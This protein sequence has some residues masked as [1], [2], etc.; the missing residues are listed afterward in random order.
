MCCYHWHLW[1][2]FGWLPFA[3][4]N[5]CLI[6]DRMCL[7]NPIVTPL[8]VRID[9]TRYP[10]HSWKVCS[11]KFQCRSGRIGQTFAT[12]AEV[13]Q[14]E[15]ALLKEVNNSC[16]PRDPSLCVLKR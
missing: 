5:R 7:S 10:N 9:L 2:V 14:I 12:I 13:K 4:N 6:R 15:V 1:G 8:V 16:C 3:C 11:I